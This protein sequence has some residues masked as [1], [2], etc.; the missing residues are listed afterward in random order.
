MHRRRTMHIL[1]QRCQNRFP[2]SRPTMDAILAI[3]IPLLFVLACGWIRYQP[4]LKF[5]PIP[6]CALLVVLTGSVF[7][8]EFYAIS[9]GPIPI[10]ID[11][12][13]LVGLVLC[14]VVLFFQGKEDIRRLNWLDISILIL[15]SVITFSTLTHDWQF[16][17]NM[18]ASRLLF[19]NLMPLFL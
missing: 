11:R 5:R 13:L 19:F 7:G 2:F 16:L 8:R 10:S 9:A 3:V 18:P 15:M 6:L 17:K 12:V 1:A 4:T 14:F